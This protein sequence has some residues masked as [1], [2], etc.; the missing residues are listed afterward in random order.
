[1]HESADKQER[2][3]ASG[4]ELKSVAAGNLL[5]RYALRQSLR[6]RAQHDQLRADV[7]SKLNILESK[8]GMAGGVGDLA[9]HK[10][11]SPQS[12]TFAIN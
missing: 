7:A 2:A 8:H 1:M 6:M 5:F 12:T 11:P 9:N 4:V 10:F 3:A